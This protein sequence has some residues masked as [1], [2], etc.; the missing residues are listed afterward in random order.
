[1][2]ASEFAKY[3]FE[4]KEF[5]TPLEGE[6]QTFLYCQ[7]AESEF[8]FLDNNRGNLSIIFKKGV[9][10]Q[11]ANEIAQMLQDN[12]DFFSITKY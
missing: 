3:K 6:A 11:R 8:A 9:S 1:M 10:L 7:P 12:V 2:P 5:D 4:V